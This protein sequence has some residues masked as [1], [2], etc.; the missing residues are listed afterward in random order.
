M[1]LYSNDGSLGLR[2]NNAFTG[3]ADAVAIGQTTAPNSSAMLDIVSTT[4][5][6]L[7][8][9]MTTTQVNAITTPPNG[10][11]VYNTT[12]DHMCVYQGGSW[13]RINHSPM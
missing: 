3:I 13:V 2:V 4:K 5:G 9:R 12:I 7:P 6:L 10:L 1:D 11:R 8:P